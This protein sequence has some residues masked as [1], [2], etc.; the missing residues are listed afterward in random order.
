M[1][2]LEKLAVSRRFCWQRHHIV[3]I[4]RK[5]AGCCGERR[6]PKYVERIITEVKDGTLS[7][8]VDGK[9]WNNWNWGNKKLKAYVTATDLD[10]FG[11]SGGSIAKLTDEITV[12]D[13]K[14]DVSGG[15]IIEGKLKGNKYGIRS[16]WW[17]H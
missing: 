11:A 8:R 12:N 16:Q 7:I 17:K 5:R 1:Q 10:Y 15:S 3:F 9:M 4:T 14:C 13:L 6:R 2:K